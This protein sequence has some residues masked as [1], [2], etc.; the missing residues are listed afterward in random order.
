M[1]SLVHGTG[2]WGIAAPLIGDY[3]VV[4]CAANDGQHV[5]VKKE[6]G[7]KARRLERHWHIVPVGTAIGM[8][9]MGVDV[10]QESR[11][12]FVPASA[13]QCGRKVLFEHAIALFVNFTDCFSDHHRTASA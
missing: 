9:A 13:N 3:P 11:P 4:H 2:E 6:S 5:I 12:K 7:M 1:E 8:I 10:M